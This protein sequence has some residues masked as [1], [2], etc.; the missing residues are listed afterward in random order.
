MK[1]TPMERLE[2]TV[3]EP[4]VNDRF[5]VSRDAEAT[6]ELVLKEAKTAGPRGGSGGAGFSLLFH[7]PDTIF[8]PQ[9]MYRFEHQTLGKF[10]LFI[11]PVARE[12]GQYH[13]QAIFNRAR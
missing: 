4:L 11:V 7:G 1:E 2:L 3:F 9:R 13:Y 12:K 8:L 5:V 10:E 6:V